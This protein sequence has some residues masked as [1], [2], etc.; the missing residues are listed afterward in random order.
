MSM[1]ATL[2]SNV[3]SACDS[4]IVGE[5]ALSGQQAP[6]FD[7]PDPCPDIPWPQSNRGS[8]SHPTIRSV[9]AAIALRDLASVGYEPAVDELLPHLPHPGGHV[10]PY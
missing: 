1:Y 3:Q 8:L 2:K 6:V 4:T 5:H 7:T 9:A 10:D